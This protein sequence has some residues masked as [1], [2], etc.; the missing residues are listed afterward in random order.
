[1]V[2]IRLMLLRKDFQ[3]EVG[4]GSMCDFC[5]NQSD[6]RRSEDEEL[7]PCNAVSERNGRSYHPSLVGLEGDYESCDHYIPLSLDEMLVTID[8]NFGV[9]NVEE[10][11]NEDRMARKY[12][13]HFG[14]SMMAFWEHQRE[15]YQDAVKH[16]ADTTINLWY[17]AMVDAQK[18]NWRSMKRDIRREG[19]DMLNH[20]NAYPIG[21]V[22]G[23][24]FRI[25]GLDEN[26]K[27]FGNSLIQ[28][29]TLL[30]TE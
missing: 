17:M 19:R 23:D 24:E 9:D 20:K 13:L 15:G 11:K 28:L 21:G 2:E 26:W 30:P 1:M 7:W 8:A 16:E 27:R 22:P 25:E 5:S 29:A 14:S 3:P 12:A 4:K 6:S 18:G 10:Y